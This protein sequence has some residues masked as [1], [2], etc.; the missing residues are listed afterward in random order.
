MTEAQ[1][2][3]STTL[4]A[5]RNRLDKAERL[6]E[7][8]LEV[9][10]PRMPD[11]AERRAIECAAGVRRCSDETWLQALEIWNGRR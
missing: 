7:F 2:Y 3:F 10:I 5:K 4:K 9:R 8:M 1:H 6:V 11:K